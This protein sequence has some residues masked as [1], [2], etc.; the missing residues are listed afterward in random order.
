MRLSNLC[1]A[2]NGPPPPLD[3][4]QKIDWEIDQKANRVVPLI[5]RRLVIA[6]SVAMLLLNG[7][8]L[9]QGIQQQRNEVE[10]SPPAIE[11]QY[12]Q[13]SNFKIYE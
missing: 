8:A 6:A 12:L 7:A 2:V 5:P 3:L 4:L 11:A 1:K 13:I 10:Q 9:F